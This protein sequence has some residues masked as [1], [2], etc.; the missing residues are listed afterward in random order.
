MFITHD[1][2]LVRQIAHRTDAIYP[3]T[4]V[5]KPRGHGHLRWDSADPHRGPR[6]ES[7]LFDG[8]E[9]IHAVAPDLT[10]YGIALAAR[11]HF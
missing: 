11:G 7:A 6:I 3:A 8:W 10:L 4:V 2:N 5:G 1:I 9:L